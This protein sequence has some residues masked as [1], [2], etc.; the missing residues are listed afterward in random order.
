MSSPD[1]RGCNVLIA[2]GVDNWK[3]VAR[4]VVIGH[5]KCHG[6]NVF[7]IRIDRVD[8]RNALCTSKRVVKSNIVRVSV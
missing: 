7:G 3:V 5:S 2:E 8:N 1:I 6:R 4:F